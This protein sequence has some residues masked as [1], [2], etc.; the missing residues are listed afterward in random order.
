MIRLSDNLS[1]YV[2]KA[3]KITDEKVNMFSEEELAR[4][5]SIS[6]SR[7]DISVVKYFKNLIHID[8][9]SYPSLTTED[10][11]FIGNELPNISSLKIKEQNSIYRL[12]LSS[13]K[14]LKRIE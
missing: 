10:V 7:D 3:L 13:Y 11:V 8:F 9:N 5:T 2:R 14:N 12:D 1:R 4:I 6:I